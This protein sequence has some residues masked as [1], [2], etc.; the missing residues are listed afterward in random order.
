MDKLEK[1]VKQIAFLQE[2]YMHPETRKDAR[3]GIL[4][5]SKL[6]NPS[7]VRNE[8][9]IIHEFLTPKQRKSLAVTQ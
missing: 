4:T 2:S 8:D 6:M 5:L 1:L 7:D 3:V 9:E